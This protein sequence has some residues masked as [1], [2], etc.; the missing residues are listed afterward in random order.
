MAE[1]T[2]NLDPNQASEPISVTP[3]TLVGI[4]TDKPASVTS[5]AGNRLLNLGHAD[6]QI[7]I[8]PTDEITITAGPLGATVVLDLD[9]LEV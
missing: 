2:L 4:E 3:R 6:S 9:S 8:P 7:L 1:Q 5:K